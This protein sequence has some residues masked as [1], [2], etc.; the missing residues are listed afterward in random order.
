MSYAPA[1]SDSMVWNPAEGNSNRRPPLRHGPGA[2]KARRA[3]S[4]APGHVPRGEDFPIIAHCHLCWDW[5]WQRPQQ[6]LSRLSRRHEVLFVETLGPDPGLASPATRF[7]Q[8]ADYPNLTVLR[9]QFPTW[10]WERG[11]LVDRERRRLVRE[12][13]AQG[14]VAG[15]FD[16]AVQ[17]FYDP[18]A[19]RAFAGHL[20]EVLTVYDCMDELSKF[21]CA[22]P[23]IASRELELLERADV[24]FAGGRRLHQAKSLFN[25]NCHFY[26]CGVDVE[27]FGKARRAETGVPA[28]LTSLPRPVL[29]YFGVIDERI[30]YKLLRQLAAAHP[31][32]S[33]VMVGPTLKVDPEALPRAANLHWL[34][35]RD[36]AEL[37]ALCKGFDACLMPFALNESTEYINPTKALEYM[38]AGR[39]IVSTPVPDVVHNFG[40][41]VRIAATPEEFS[42]ACRE[43]V[44]RP[45]RE[46]V[47]RG[48]K[49]AAGQTWETIVEAL[50]RHVREALMKLATK[51]GAPA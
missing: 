19:V 6:F 31:G 25:E 50:E 10:I 11:E 20:N 38:A 43:A 22:P 35:K 14:P 4:P 49:M 21:R 12:F 1:C 37:P 7:Y 23:E 47:A 45:N 28:E 34:G 51:N 16:Q 29:G 2:K 46:A 24:V 44:E 41:V 3:K 13:L 5:V 36:Y 42:A 18:M 30:D 33:M 17:W 27:H 39:P 9:A 48:L 40:A 32:W 8:P 26:G 15:Q